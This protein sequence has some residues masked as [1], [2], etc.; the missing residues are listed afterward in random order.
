MHALKLAL[1]TLLRE[2]R[3]GEL[4]V[5]LLALTTAV[6]ALT[7]VGF[8]VGRIDTAVREQATQVLAADLR[9]SSTQPL[10][11]TLFA[12]AARRGV[13]AARIETL[14]SVVFRGDDSQLANVEAVS[15]GYPLRGTLL[16]ADQ[17]FA[18][19]T[20]TQAIPGRGEVWP[21]S[22]LLATLG[23]GIGAQLSIGAASLKVTRV[24]IARPDQGANLSD[25][26][27]SLIMNLE[28]LPATQLIQPGS[29]VSY[30]GLFA[31][32][33]AV[34]AAF[35]PWL[36]DNARP[37]DR[38]RDV[39]EASPQLEN[40]V[41]RAGRF[42]TLASLV[43]VLLCSIAVAMS[44]RQYVRRHLDAVALLKTLG[45]TRGFTLSVSLLQLI[46]VALLASLAG[47]VIGFLAQEWLLRAVRD[48]LGTAILPP[49]NLAPLGMGVTAALAVLAGFA[50]PPLLQLARVPPLRVLRRDVGPPPPLVILAFGPA[51]LVVIGL[52]GWAVRDIR[53]ALQF[54]VGLA[55]FLAVLAG[56]GF[57]LVTLCGRLRGRVGVAWRY[58][59]ANLNR[60]R[61]DSMVQIAA[62]GAGLMVLLVLGVVR[63]DLEND[64]RRSLPADAPNYFFVNIPPADRNG[65][66]Q[67]LEQRGARLSR[68]LPMLRGRLTA[69]NGQSVESMRFAA[70]QGRGFSGRE[71]NVTWASALGNDNQIVS[72]EWWPADYHGAPQVS[73]ATEFQESLGVAV[74]DKVSFDIGGEPF[75]ATVS[76]IRKVKWDSFQPNFFV[77]FSPGVLDAVAGTFLT[78]AYFHPTD[79]HVMA[80][81]ARRFPSVSI[82]N[83]DDL[84]AQV[85]GII[86]KAI[87]AVQSVF[88]FTLFAGLVV[89]LA[90]V[91]SS[92]EERR[93]ESAMLRTLGASGAIV[94]QGVMAEF[95]ALGLLAGGLAV[96]GAALAGAFVATRVLQVPYAFDPW[97]PVIGVGGGALLVCISGW[98]A[99]R[100]VI[101]QPPM[102]TLRGG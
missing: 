98:L 53:L 65:F 34:I 62:F 80:Q 101:S 32:D 71:Q 99:T 63:D 51:V 90:A 17:P 25:L 10:P 37:S 43:S 22:K 2:W 50:V 88:A 77:V 11:D 70:G 57:A 29:R 38:L 85:R 18:T 54:L 52:V 5:L 23:G 46:T 6:A 100:S 60:R 8:L 67:F 91:Q 39:S 42:L 66:T 12:G 48:L 36:L 24:L 55:A 102:L 56:A 82:F 44:A 61:A 95:V 13:H 41:D 96:A 26:A 76:S 47:S 27:P 1:R 72:G 75:V 19:G 73:L 7:G 89:L 87:L 93:F 3:S 92:R 86:D 84:L 83:V 33:P 28:D 69:I 58:G 15:D 97:L 14:L 40:A 94:W 79:P 9:I 16:V 74:G 49:A 4:G 64:W 31:A 21:S 30:S 45:A 59:I 35:R 78:S 68:V 81:L 20:A